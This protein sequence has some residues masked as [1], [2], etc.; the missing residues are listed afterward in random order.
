MWKGKRMSHDRGCPCGREPY[1]YD[2]CTVINFFKRENKMDK[3]NLH[4]ALA[5]AYF[6]AKGMQMVYEE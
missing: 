3:N 5:D 4:N 2:D 1:E 6:Q